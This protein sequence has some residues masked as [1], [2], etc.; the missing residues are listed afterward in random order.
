[1][2][3]NRENK[4]GL[5]NGFNTTQLEGDVIS[6]MDLIGWVIGGMLV[7]LQPGIFLS[8]KVANIL[9]CIV[10]L[11]LIYQGMYHYLIR[12][13]DSTITIFSQ[14]VS[15]RNQVVSRSMDLALWI[16]YQGFRFWKYPNCFEVTS[17]FEIE[18]H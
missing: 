9:S 18:W 15:M 14:Q 12:Q 3:I 1:M 10:V 4:L 17:K 16:G 5:F 2:W 13:N 8:P 6:A 11:L 7:S